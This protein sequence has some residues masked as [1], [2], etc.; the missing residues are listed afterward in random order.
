MIFFAD[1]EILFSGNPECNG[2]EVRKVLNWKREETHDQMY[3]A[4]E[5]QILEVDQTEQQTF[6]QMSDSS[7]NGNS[8]DDLMDILNIPKDH[9][10]DQSRPRFTGDRP[11]RSTVIRSR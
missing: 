6:D 2:D 5:N 1:I 3:M 11:L 4:S 10:L 7:H 9:L 8:E